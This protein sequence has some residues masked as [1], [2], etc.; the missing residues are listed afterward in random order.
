MIWLGGILIVNLA[1][2]FKAGQDAVTPFVALTLFMLAFG[3]GF[4]A[5]GRLLARDEGPALMDFIR[6]TTGAQD[7]PAE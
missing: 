7:L 5:F 3:L 4:V 2:L 6:Q 1:G